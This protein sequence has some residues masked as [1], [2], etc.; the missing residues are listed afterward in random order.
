MR[1]PLTGSQRLAIEWAADNAHHFGGNGGNI[2]VAGLSAG[3]YSAQM[4]LAYELNTDSARSLISRAMLFSNA[5]P[6]QCKSVEESQAGLDGLAEACGISADLDGKEKMAR[7][8]QVPMQ[9]LVDKVM[10]L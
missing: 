7:L 6:A 5:L 1:T 2:T 3:A 10:H 9:E 4:Q 8:R